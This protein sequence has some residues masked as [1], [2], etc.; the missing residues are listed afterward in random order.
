MKCFA[1]STN[2]RSG[3]PVWVLLTAGCFWSF[4][5]FAQAALSDLDALRYIASHPDLIAAFGPDA[6][7]GRSHYE[8]WGV[9]EGRK[10][11]FE[12][13]Y[14]TASHPDLIEAFAADDTKATTHYIRWGH[15]EKRQTTFSTLQALR[16]IASQPDLIEAFGPDPT[17]GVRHYLQWGY[18][19]NRRITFEPSRYMASHPD[20]I[21]A[22]AGDEIKAARHYIEWGYKEQRQTTF[23]DLN[24]LQ[25]IASFADLIQAFGTDVIAGI[26]HYVTAGYRE[27]RKIIFDAIAYLARHV[28]VKQAFGSDVV[29]ATLHYINYGY[30]EGRKI[31]AYTLTASAGSGGS[32]VPLRLIVDHDDRAVF[33]LTPAEGFTT[34]SVSGCPGTLSGNLF[35][36]AAVRGECLLVV[37]FV[38]LPPFSDVSVVLPD[39]ANEYRSL[40][41][42]RNLYR[43]ELFNNFP[44]VQSA[45]VANLSR[46]ADGRVDLVFTL[47]CAISGGTVHRGSIP[48]GAVFFRQKS[49]GSFFNATRDLFGVDLLDQGGV[50]WKPAV[51]DINGDGY[52]EVL[53][54][55]L[56]EDGR[57]GYEGYTV[58]RPSSFVSSVGGGYRHDLKG[59]SA[60]QLSVVAQGNG[61][62]DI[63]TAERAWRWESGDWAEFSGY[64]WFKL[65]TVFFKPRSP[66][67]ATETAIVSRGMRLEYWARTPG[68]PAPATGLSTNCIYCSQGEWFEKD[69]L[70]LPSETVPFLTWRREQSVIDL[71]TVDGVQYVYP[72]FEKSCEIRRY[73]DSTPL[74]FVAFSGSKLDKPYVAGVVL[75]EG[76]QMTPT[77]LPLFY[78]LSTGKL[79]KIPVPVVNWENSV[80]PF[81]LECVDVNN[82]SHD[83]IVLFPG[84]GRERGKPYIYLND[85]KGGFARVDAKWFPE[86]P[87]TFSEITGL[88]RDV[89][90]DGIR[91]IV[92]WPLIPKPLSDGQEMRFALFKGRRYLSLESDLQ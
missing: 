49:D 21:E 69:T 32:V 59:V 25:Y 68:Q 54:P 20:L 15:Q 43:P 87:S 50:A 89:D 17:R 13:L 67:G 26:R 56:G 31:A 90:G 6:S 29:A 91:D 78:E 38:R 44:S 37:N 73:P 3:L 45:T 88:Y 8:T 85:R 16:Y 46:H 55:I 74:S 41:A 83:D 64:R 92:Y 57:G 79:I 80:S 86:S 71:V 42:D 27:G 62:F 72:L 70:I 77:V 35:T 58:D 19:E 30:R 24:A 52:D 81:D 33:T 66:G 47:W 65:G 5:A 1:G 7:K 51:L 28:D 4:A 84:G 34:G 36:T 23:S 53:W 2:K 76:K 14:Y 63:A 82:D 11:T 9:K 48:N 40:C 75:E 61:R 22:F 10:I 60:G 12:P 39:V 18:R